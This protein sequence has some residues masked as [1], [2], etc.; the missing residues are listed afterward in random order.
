[1]EIAYIWGEI[2]GQMLA[3]DRWANTSL[4]NCEGTLLPIQFQELNHAHDGEMSHLKPIV[5]QPYG[6]KYWQVC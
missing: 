4:S 5:L 1:M 2:T 3:G 6:P